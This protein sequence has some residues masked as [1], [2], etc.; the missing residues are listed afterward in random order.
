MPQ[1]ARRLKIRRKDLRKPDEFET[2]TGQVVAWANEHLPIVY[3]VL[4]VVLLVMIAGLGLGR[5]RASQNEAASIAFRSAQGRFAAGK[6]PEAAE[7][8]AYVLEHYPHTS[9]GRIAGLYRAHALARQGDQAGAVTGYGEFLAHAP[10]IDYL[11]Q[12]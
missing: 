9:Y 7:E 2:L 12:E 4:A 11:R 8:F 10:A 3:G 6:F 1:H 5:W